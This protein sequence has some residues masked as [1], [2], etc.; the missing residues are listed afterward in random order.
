MKASVLVGPV[1]ASLLMAAAT[2]PSHTPKPGAPLQEDRQR[3]QTPED[4]P[5]LEPYEADKD[6]TAAVEEV[7]ATHRFYRP[8]IITRGQSG[9]VWFTS[10][11]MLEG[12]REDFNS[13]DRVFVGVAASGEVRSWMV[14]Y[15]RGASVWGIRGRLLG[16][17]LRAEATLIAKEVESALRKRGG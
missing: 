9:V 11:R 17:D 14:G 13:F 5:F 8:F 16:G 1:V 4:S 15:V 10:D 2:P 7:F 12:K 6:V 3:V